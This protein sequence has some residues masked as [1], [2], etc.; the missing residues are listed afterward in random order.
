[1]AVSR[2]VSARRR[3]S[4]STGKRTS[5]MYFR[6]VPGHPRG[7]E[8]RRTGIICRAVGSAVRVVSPLGIRRRKGPINSNETS[9]RHRSGSSTQTVKET[10][11]TG[12]AI[13]SMIPM[14]SAGERSSATARRKDGHLVT[15]QNKG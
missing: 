15:R 4:R 7:C 10:M 1:M 3:R 11:Q 9:S 12:P 13:D 2:A 5:R 14:A 8:V 6:R